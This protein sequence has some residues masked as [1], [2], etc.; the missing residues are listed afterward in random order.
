MITALNID[1]KIDLFLKPDL[2]IERLSTREYMISRYF[3]CLKHEKRLRGTLVTIHLIYNHACMQEYLITTA[4]TVWN[5]Q[6][7]IQINHK[8]SSLQRRDKKD[9]RK[10]NYYANQ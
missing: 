1:V 4:V 7:T 3:S 2:T 5:R 6:V 9:N 10:K 8:R